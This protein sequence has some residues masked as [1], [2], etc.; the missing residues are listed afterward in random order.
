MHFWLSDWTSVSTWVEG[1]S[2][3]SFVLG[4]VVKSK[5]GVG[6]L[7]T[8]SP[9]W[10]CSVCASKAGAM[11]FSSKFCSSS[12]FSSLSSCDIRSSLACCSSHFSDKQSCSAGPGEYAVEASIFV[13]STLHSS[14]ISSSFLVSVAWRCCSCSRFLA[15]CFSAFFC[16][17]CSFFSGSGPSVVSGALGTDSGGLD[18]TSS[19]SDGLLFAISFAFRVRFLSF[20]LT[21]PAFFVDIGVE[22]DASSSARALS[23]WCSAASSSNFLFFKVADG[24]DLCDQ[25]QVRLTT[26]PS[27]KQTRICMNESKSTPIHPRGANTEARVSLSCIVT[28]GKKFE[29]IGWIVGS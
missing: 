4:S 22:S 7:S 21:C 18:V 28:D 3:A 26:K 9:P 8:C 25:V 17:F 5:G 19:P 10:K 15:R 1:V 12:F 23:E 24:I 13:S 16:A 11:E 2:S 6:G 29:W 20:A 14:V 27:T